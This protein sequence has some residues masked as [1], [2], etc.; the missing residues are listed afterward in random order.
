MAELPY[1]PTPRR[2]S[3]S[4]IAKA[5]RDDALAV[6][7]SDTCPQETRDAIEYCYAALCTI[8]TQTNFWNRP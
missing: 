2:L 8:D 4:E 1:L 6:F 7:D 3:L 5:V